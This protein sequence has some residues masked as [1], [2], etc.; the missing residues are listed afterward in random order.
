MKTLSPSEATYLHPVD[1]DI[2]P[3]KA[4][5]FFKICS[6]SWLLSK[7]FVKRNPANPVQPGED[8]NYK[9]QILL[10]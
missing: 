3:P 8:I 10:S 7:F 2:P 9:G 5:L 4:F 1:P 6:G